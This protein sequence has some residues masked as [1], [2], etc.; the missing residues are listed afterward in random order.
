MVQS[1]S[2]SGNIAAAL[3]AASQEREE[4]RRRMEAEQAAAN[5]RLT[6]EGPKGQG[7]PD[8]DLDS[9]IAANIQPP[10]LTQEEKD[11]QKYLEGYQ[12]GKQQRPETGLDDK[13]PKRGPTQREL[14]DRQYGPGGI[15][16]ERERR[17]QAREAAAGRNAEAKA[18][19]KKRNEENRVRRPS[20]GEGRSAELGYALEVAREE[21]GQA[22]VDDFLRKQFPEFAE[23]RDSGMATNPT[24]AERRADQRRDANRR[25]DNARD[26]RETF[27]Q[28][29][30]SL[31]NRFGDDAP[32]LMRDRMMLAEARTPSYDM[33]DVMPEGFHR[34]DPDVQRL[35][36]RRGQEAG[37]VTDAD[38]EGLLRNGDVSEAT[39]RAE[40]AMRGALGQETPA[41]QA[42]RLSEQGRAEEMGRVVGAGGQ[43][44]GNFGQQGVGRPED[45]A[46]RMG[47]LYRGNVI[48]SAAQGFG[49]YFR[50]PL[51]TTVDFYDRNIVSPARDYFN[52]ILDR[53]LPR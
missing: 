33:G 28:D 10:P 18:K 50:D 22:A 12:A 35:R 30:S 43:V 17:F 52:D 47:T 32:R 36:V 49:D 48:G 39:G 15:E 5:A 6:P 40:M 46:T 24:Q 51:G 3:M 31:R 23:A 20:G 9:L 11:F 13:K 26:F 41:E 7:A 38:M 2:T 25:A 21:G 53:I 44:Q 1:V 37:R 29:A 42:M 34:L 19:I 16:A 45:A 8:E 27:G 4:A 14:R